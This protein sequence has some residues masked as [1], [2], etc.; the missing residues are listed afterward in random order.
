MSKN[1]AKAWW[2]RPDEYER[3][4]KWREWVT[5]RVASDLTILLFDELKPPHHE[6]V[7]E[8]EAKAK[9]LELREIARDRKTDDVTS[10]KFPKQRRH[11]GKKP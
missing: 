6:T 7:T 9:A 3:A 5:G 10:G 11:L 2:G 8:A 4:H 1:A